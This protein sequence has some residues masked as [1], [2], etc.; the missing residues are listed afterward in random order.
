MP[1]QA[2]NRLSRPARIAY[3]HDHALR[4]LTCR[5]LPGWSFRRIRVCAAICGRSHLLRTLLVDEPVAASSGTPGGDELDH[6]LVDPDDLDVGTVEL[7]NQAGEAG[8]RRPDRGGVRVIG[9]PHRA[10]TVWRIGARSHPGARAM[11]IHRQGWRS[12]ATMPKREPAPMSNQAMTSNRAPGACRTADDPAP[13][14][15]GRRA[16]SVRSAGPGPGR[17][18]STCWCSPIAMFRDL[19]EREPQ[20]RR[21]TP[22]RLRRSSSSSA[23]S[24]RSRSPASIARG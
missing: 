13:P 20:R 4:R 8:L 12:G 10:C 23:R 15:G 5:R 18:S 16:C 3:W 22:V 7:G 9:H 2:V 1:A 6:R 21:A 19:G 14:G 17:C 24:L 11:T